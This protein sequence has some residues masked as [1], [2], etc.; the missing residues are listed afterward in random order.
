MKKKK[1]I[2]FG[3]FRKKTIEKTVWKAST[4]KI[5]LQYLDSQFEA[6][7]TVLPRHLLQHRLKSY[8]KTHTQNNHDTETKTNTENA[9]ET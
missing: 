9:A 5:K 4:P 3:Y 8:G 7:T 1:R 2:K 6:L